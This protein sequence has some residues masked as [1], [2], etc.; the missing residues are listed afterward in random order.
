MG[1]THYW[2]QTRDFS[3]TEW[4]EVTQN[5]CAIVCEAVERGVPIGNGFG[6]KMPKG[7][8]ETGEYHVA[9]N[10]IG[11]DRCETF[12]LDKLLPEGVS[13]AFNFCKTRNRP[14]DI[15]VVACLCYL[16]SA[17]PDHISVGSD[18]G[19]DD[20]EDGLEIARKALPDLRNDIQIPEEITQA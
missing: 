4:N 14:Y 3:K 6:E 19:L 16:E 9:F 1:Y 15:A 7:A 8:P 2:N 5:V 13:K 18:G 12:W 17:F 20:W 11:E 10:G